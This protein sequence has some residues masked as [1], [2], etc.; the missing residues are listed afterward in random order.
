MIDDIATNDETFS[1]SSDEE[2]DGGEEFRER[3]NA[4]KDGTDM[5]YNPMSES[6]PKLPA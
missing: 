3:V 6:L 5:K 2:F 4:I 1:E